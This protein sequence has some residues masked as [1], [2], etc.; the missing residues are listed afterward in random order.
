M[1]AIGEQRRGKGIPGMAREL[2]AVEVEGQRLIAIDAATGW[3]STGLLAHD[4]RLAFFFTA[5]GFSPI[6]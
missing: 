3:Q 4:S 1:N 6:L 2:P 5:G